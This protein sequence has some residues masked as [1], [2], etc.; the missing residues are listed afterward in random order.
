MD[1]EHISH[2]H[3]Q[4][5]ASVLRSSLFASTTEMTDG[6]ADP[7]IDPEK[8]AHPTTSS[9][10]A[11]TLPAPLD[12]DSAEHSTA[13]ETLKRWNAKFEKATGLET[14][15]IARVPLSERHSTVNISSYLQIVLLWISCDLTAN[16][17]T[18]AML[19]P[20]VF[21][22]PFTDAA[23]CAVF[24]AWIGSLG[25]AY[26]STFGPRSGHRTMVAARWFMG[27]YPSK[28]TAFLTL[29]VMVGY[30][31]INCIIT[32]QMLSAVNGGGLS[33]IPGIIIVSV[34][35][36]VI[37]LFGMKAFHAY[38]R[39]AWF[40][41]LLVMFILIGSAGGNFNTS[42]TWAENIT[43]QTKTAHR[44]SYL[45]LCLSSP[46]AWASSSADYFVY[47]PPPPKAK[48]RYIAL[49]TYFGNSLT[50]TLTYMLGVGLASGVSS[51]PSWSAAY[52]ESQGA[53]ILAGFSS[54][55]TFGKFCGVVLALGIIADQ[56]AATYSAG[57]VVQIMDSKYLGRT[58]RWL[59]T[60]GVVIVYTAC[61][62]GGREV[63]FDI[64]QNFL[65][66]IGYWC[67]FFVF[68]VLEE[69]LLFRYVRLQ[70]LWS[71]EEH[72]DGFTWDAF[73][74]EPMMPPGYAA[75]SAFLISWA[76][77]IISMKQ[78]W[79]TGPL[80]RLVGQDGCDL[81]LWVGGA[82]T[83]VVFPVL[84]YVEVKATKR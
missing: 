53:L 59:V 71:G 6:I 74:Q 66:L 4:N 56:I 31:T 41:Q 12:N 58:P 70:R 1:L 16:G 13:W 9:S 48:R 81:G 75:L 40:P 29:V 82:V 15:G 2:R 32:G 27:Y 19:G 61:A 21:K 43:T 72:D 50:F 57:I 65:A 26:I 67:V 35:T 28:I 77:A 64:F 33:L 5:K 18:L 54:L 79:Y 84:R 7:K 25:P 23:L 11:S 22:L 20:L 10:E 68:I 14:R 49:A 8:G 3:A 38:E 44:L 37:A 78:A 30:G 52:E 83:L 76:A 34:V 73:D 62:I 55:G 63:L 51:N 69:H 60:V 39:Y 80:A 47:Y 42:S 46:L 17:I 24:G 36:M 45:S